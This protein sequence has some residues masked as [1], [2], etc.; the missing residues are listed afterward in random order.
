MIQKTMLFAFM[1]FSVFACGDSSTGPVIEIEQRLTSSS[2]NSD[3][4]IVI[5]DGRITPKSAYEI[6]L[7]GIHAGRTETITISGDWDWWSEEKNIPLYVN[8]SD[9]VLRINDPQK[10]LLNYAETIFP[11]NL[12]SIHIVVT[13][14]VI[15]R[16]RHP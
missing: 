10:N 9:G 7:K 11:N 16:W 15:H 6:Q 12:S 3:G 8:V 5:R 1:A 14:W 2:Y 13:V 4:D